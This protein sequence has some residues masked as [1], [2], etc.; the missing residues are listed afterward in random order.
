MKKLVLFPAIFGLLLSGCSLED[1]KF[2]EQKDTTPQNEQKEGEHQGEE[3]SGGEE[4][5]GGGETTVAVKG[6]ALNKT[7][8]SLE[9][10]QSEKLTYTIDPSNATNKKVE[11]STSDG[12]VAS[13][14][15]GLV[16]AINPGTASITVTTEDGKK[17]SSC[18]VNVSKKESQAKTITS[19]LVF[20][21]LGY[22]T[23]DTDY[24][25][26][27]AI[28]ENVSVVFAQG[29]STLVPACYKGSKTKKYEARAYWGNT[30]TITSKDGAIKEIVLTFSTDNPGVNPITSDVG[31]F[32]TNTWTGSS[33]TIVFTVG[34]ESGHRRISSIKVTYEGEENPT[35]DI[36]LGV[37]TIAEVKEY[38][39]NHPVT[40]NAFGNGVNE[41]RTV[42]IKGFAL[43]KI[44]LEKAKSEYGLDV[45]EF[46]KVIMADSTGYI[47]VASKVSGEGTSLYGKVGTYT[48]TD[49]ARYVVTGYL[50][51][52]LG[53]PEILVTSFTWDSSLDVTWDPSVIS[54]A[55]V[56]I[57]NFY[58]K[59]KDVYYNCAGHGYGE[60][61]TLNNL[62]LYYTEADG[63]G[64]RYYNFTDGEKNI[65]VNAYN[66]GSVS[67]GK[68]YD[69]V[70]ITSI[71]NLSPIIV[72]FRISET[73]NP[74]EFTFN[75]WTASE[76]TS[77]S[78]LYTVSGSQ[79]DVDTRTE[80]FDDVIEAYGKFYKTEVY[81]T[82]VEQGGLYYVGVTEN[83]LSN[84]TIDKPITGKDNA[85]TNYGVT[86]IK[87][88]NF[89]AAEASEIQKYNPFF[90]D[91]VCEE[92]PLTIYYT[93]R[94]QRYVSKTPIW[95]ILLI[96]DSLHVYSE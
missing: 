18:T 93:V 6:I 56:T 28:D 42:T 86:L 67:E 73:V 20:N 94:Q 76:T 13:V 64:I 7:S 54:D 10:L 72:A 75:Y 66:L 68:Y 82:L 79:D 34:G 53:H 12:T 8:L 46:G 16:S 50:S 29:E 23:D 36:N 27:V 81:L 26:P 65:R 1:L 92:L 63:Q 51:E 25:D 78:K 33:Q 24:T 21:D 40:K 77:L 48:C 39:Q 95:E 96:E 37:K 22:T 2:W 61:L 84:V 47:G 70:G 74:E 30:F 89:W 57:E 60:V 52:Y 38:I 49:T 3:G 58:N 17:T 15:D 43:A 4:Q 44:N 9:E 45:S 31:E 59:A 62:K 90:E 71:K 11:W 87:N 69:I 88:Q 83:F 41:H 91:Y 14:V 55:T 35:E 32:D 80:R 19:N 5:G 85:C